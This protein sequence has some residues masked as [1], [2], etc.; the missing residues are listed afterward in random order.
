MGVWTLEQKVWIANWLCFWFSALDSG[1]HG[2]KDLAQATWREFWRQDFRSA[3][4]DLGFEVI[5]PGVSWLQLGFRVKGFG[6]TW[7]S[8][9]HAKRRGR[10]SLRCLC[11][12]S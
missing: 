11:A 8:Y 10:Q 9:L 6:I 5:G 12:P 3:F 1:A 4:A 2:I 7:T